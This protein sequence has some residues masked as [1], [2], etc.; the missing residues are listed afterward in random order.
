MNS[1][2]RCICA[3]AVHA[4]LVPFSV[5][6][7]PTQDEARE[8]LRKVVS[9]YRSV[10]Y[11]GAY[12]WKYAADL[13]AQEG[14]GV[15]SRTSGWTQPPGT[16][17]VGEALLTAWRLSGEQC[18]L[19]AAVEAAHALV[20]SQL[21]SG[22]WSSHFDLGAEGR[23]RYRYRI[24]GDSAGRNDLT[25]LDD[26]KTQSALLLLMHVDEALGFSDSRIHECV[27]Y[28]L[29]HLSAA[30][31]PNGA[32]PQQFSGPVEHQEQFPVLKASYPEDWPREYPK[33]KYISYY[34]L[35]DNNMHHVAE[36]FLEAHR[37]YGRDDCR[38]SA[39]RTGDFFILAQ[40]PAPQPG[41]AQ[42]YNAQMHPVWAR[43]FEP[44]A[45]SGGEGQGVIRTLL[46]LYEATADQRFLKPIPTAIDYYRRSRLE[47]GKLARFYELQTNRPLYFTKD[48]QLTYRDD[49]LPT[50]YGF[51]IGSDLD[52]LQK[53]YDDLQSRNPADLKLPHRQITRARL[54]SGTARRA[55]SVVK[56]LDARGAWTE[57]GRMEHSPA[58]VS[59]IDMRTLIRNLDD[60]AAYVGA[61]K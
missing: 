36:M 1:L 10:G 28:A 39:L 48:Y 11:E 6:D 33:A 13:S 49:D 41:W 45:I 8:T 27:E 37:I 17:A 59:L 9:F 56:Q 15:A 58:P 51:I 5:A 32:W 61:E 50:H 7:P 46:L 14:E 30:Q 21:D 24:D 26:D 3:L 40:M 54:S 22:G 19:D 29:K 12:L 34:T 23:R 53:K 52:S 44:P 4:V 55:E 18:C 25:T 47:N 2:V 42:Q 57:T 43:K 60:L 31:Y 16:P 38:Q 20:R 35:N